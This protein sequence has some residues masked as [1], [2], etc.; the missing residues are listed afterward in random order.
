MKYHVIL[1]MWHAV[2]TST[3]QLYRDIGLAIADHEMEPIA[4]CIAIYTYTHNLRGTY[5]AIDCN[6]P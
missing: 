5:V 1:S 4:K 3:E 2:I 6:Y